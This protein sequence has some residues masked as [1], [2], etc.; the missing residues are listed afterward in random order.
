MLGFT[1]I[2]A[3]FS[4]WILDS[5]LK[6]FP[7]ARDAKTKFAFFPVG[8]N[9]DQKVKPFFQH[10]TLKF[11]QI[12]NHNFWIS[13]EFCKIIFIVSWRGEFQIWR[14]RFFISF[15]HLWSL[16]AVISEALIFGPPA[17]LK[18]HAI[19]RSSSV[20]SETLKVYLQITLAIWIILILFQC[21]RRR[22][23]VDGAEFDLFFIHSWLRRSNPLLVFYT[24][25]CTWIAQHLKSQGSHRAR[26]IN[27]KLHFQPNQATI[28]SSWRH[29]LALIYI[30][31]CLSQ[32][33]CT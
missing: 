13:L 4:H 23:T 9:T 25:S 1:A 8:K 15:P 3:R 31:R 11:Y 2:T 32:C 17:K 30:L 26:K 12:K 19:R 33:V 28:C 6:S 21:V 22:S 24:P 10:R 20:Y 27:L 7:R 29:F 18:F 5:S 16:S 14:R